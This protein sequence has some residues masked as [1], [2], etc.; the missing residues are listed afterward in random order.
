MPYHILFEGIYIV[1]SYSTA[2]GSAYVVANL[3]KIKKN[4]WIAT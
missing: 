3:L 4:I 2:I 1:S